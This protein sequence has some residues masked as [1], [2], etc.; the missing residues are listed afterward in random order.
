MID[1]TTY[2]YVVRI[3]QPPQ[4]VVELVELDVRPHY[5]DE[6]SAIR[7]GFITDAAANAFMGLHGGTFDSRFTHG[8]TKLVTQDYDTPE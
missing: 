6:H 2:P 8:T 5:Y 7:I 4:L 1:R 3:E